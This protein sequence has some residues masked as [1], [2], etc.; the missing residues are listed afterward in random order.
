M[1]VLTQRIRLNVNGFTYEL[2][3]EPWRTLLDVIREDLGL[4]GAKKACNVGDC[5]ACTVL[6]K[7]RPVNSCLVLAVDIVESD[8][9]LTIEGLAEGDALHPLQKAFMEHGAT[10]CGYC[11]PGMI[12][13]AKAVLDRNPAPREAE[14]LEAIS[15]NLC[16]CVSYRRIA[17]A[18]LAAGKEMEG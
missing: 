7:G 3:V 12:L 16:R 5:G 18:V 9:I 14:I 11:T 10:Q 13:S 2:D 17:R 4:T 15:G 6:A 8:P 1:I